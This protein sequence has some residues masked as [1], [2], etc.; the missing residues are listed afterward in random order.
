MGDAVGVRVERFVVIRVVGVGLVISTAG[1]AVCSFFS[2][3][4]KFP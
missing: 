4:T 1:V 3:Q 2:Q